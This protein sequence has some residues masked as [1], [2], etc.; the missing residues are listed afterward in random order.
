MEPLSSDA[1]RAVALWSSANL[2]LM[3]ALGLMVSR[4][5]IQLGQ[6][7]GLGGDARLERAVRA[8]GNNTEYVPGALL[9]LL[10][11]AA[12]GHSISMLHVAGG[13]LFAARVLH[14]IGIQ[15][16]EQRLPP[17]RAVGNVATWGI[18]L[19]LGVAVLVSS[20]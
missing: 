6:A 5:R 3:L 15:Q 7:V 18:T 16:R 1:L 12:T 20:F 2:L 11:A 13:A 9:L 14:A 10:L 4:L 19:W 17:A 8:H